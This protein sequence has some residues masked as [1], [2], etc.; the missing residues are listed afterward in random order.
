MPAK[1]ASLAL[2]TCDIDCVYHFALYELVEAVKEIGAEDAIEMLNV[3]IEGISVNS[4][5]CNIEAKV[6]IPA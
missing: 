1:M 2:G 4:V 5:L 6:R 3:L